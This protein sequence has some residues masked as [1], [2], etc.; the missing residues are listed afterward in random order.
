MKPIKTHG[1]VSPKTHNASLAGKT[2]QILEDKQ[3]TS[4]NGEVVDIANEIKFSMDGTVLYVDPILDFEPGDVEPAIEVVNETTADAA[5]RLYDAGKTNL[6][7][8]NFAA[9][10]NPGGGFLAG[11]NAQEEDLCRAS[12][13]YPC[14]KSKP[15]FYNE[16]VLCE[17]TY[18]TDSI[19]Y[20]P[21]VTFFR[22]KYHLLLEKPFPLSI[23]TA[24]APNVSSMGLIDNKR[25]L[26][27]L[28]NRTIK[29]LQVAALHGH[30]NIILGAWGCGAFGNDPKIVADVFK[31]A[32]LHV[33][34]FE[35]V[36]FGV[37]DTRTPPHI[38][39]TFQEVFS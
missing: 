23:V 30:K 3:Y 26:S 32:L 38:F 16:N 7:A 17:D 35:H 29:I 9:A 31:S 21:N 14:L 39:E 33:R 34:N 15:K 28:H 6:V 12:S 4:I 27:T 10:R 11:A 19:I 1:A 25:L 36:C 24:P 22:D 18:Y 13:L 20:T 2:L 37:Y 5:K 8:L